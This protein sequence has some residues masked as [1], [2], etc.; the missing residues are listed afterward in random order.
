MII[1]NT[2]ALDLDGVLSNYHYSFTKVANHLFGTPIIEYIEDVKKYRW[3]DWHPLDSKQVSSVWK[4]IDDSDHFWEDLNPL[5]SEELFDRIY[6]LSE[7]QNNILYFVTSRRQN[8]K[9]N[10]IDQTSNWI[11]KHMPNLKNFSVVTTS[12]K[13]L[14]LDAIEADVFIDDLAENICEVSQRLPKCECYFLVREY[15]SY[16]IDFFKDSHSFKNVSIVHNISEFLD[17]LK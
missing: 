9:N 11:K 2:I 3:S 4:V 13:S 5:I 15:N 6:R 7:R 8:K 1:K 14:V 12:K 10:V 17:R 16:A